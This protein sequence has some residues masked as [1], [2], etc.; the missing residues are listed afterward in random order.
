LWHD[1]GKLLAAEGNLPLKKHRD[2]IRP[3]RAHPE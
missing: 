1:F 3:I 2:T